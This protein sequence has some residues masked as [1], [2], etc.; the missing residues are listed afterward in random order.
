MKVV[1]RN[2]EWWEVRP[3]KRGFVAVCD[4]LDMRVTAAT[5]AQLLLN[6]DEVVVPERCVDG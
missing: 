6:I 4:A 2:G 3:A 5:E 1:K